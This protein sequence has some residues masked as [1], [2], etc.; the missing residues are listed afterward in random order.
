MNFAS[1][2]RSSAAGSGRAVRQGVLGYRP[3]VATSYTPHPSGRPGRSPPES[4][5]TPSRVGSVPPRPSS[6]RRNRPSSVGVGAPGRRRGPWPW[7]PSRFQAADRGGEEAGVAGATGTGAGVGDE[8]DRR[9][10]PLAPRNGSRDGQLLEGQVGQAVSDRD[11]AGPAV[12]GGRRG[13]GHGAQPRSTLGK[14]WTRG[15][16]PGPKEGGARPPGFCLRRGYCE[17]MSVPVD[18]AGLRDEVDRHGAVAY[19]LTGGADGRPHTVQ[20][21][22]RVGESRASGGPP[23]QEDRGQCVEDPDHWSA[24]CGPRSDPGGYSLIVDATVVEISGTAGTGRQL[25][26]GP[27]DQGGVAPPA[28]PLR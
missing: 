18:L 6:T 11:E 8:D 12:G 24:C 4:S 1:A 27:A 28:R 9:L 21:A 17:T 14:A 13:S 22:V 15:L 25:D 7:S 3:A 10:R 5:P 16:R 19:F 26:P 23:G 2:T 20:L